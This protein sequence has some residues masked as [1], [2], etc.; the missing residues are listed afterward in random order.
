[1]AGKIATKTLKH[2]PSAD[3]HKAIID[4]RLAAYKA[5]PSDVID[6]EKVCD[7]IEKEL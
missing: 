6:F 5:N 3:G 1:M 7:D 4:Q 2:D